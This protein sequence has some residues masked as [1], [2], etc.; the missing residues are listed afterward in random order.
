MEFESTQAT[1]RISITAGLSDESYTGGGSHKDTTYACKISNT[2]S[3]DQ[4]IPTHFKASVPPT[5][6]EL[7]SI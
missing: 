5:R 6:M 2:K 7:I 1:A 3:L 4:K